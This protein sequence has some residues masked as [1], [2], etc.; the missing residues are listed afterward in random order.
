MVAVKKQSLLVFKK[1][2]LGS[3]QEMNPVMSQGIFDLIT[4]Y[5]VI[6]AF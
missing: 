2:S 3:S 1:K 6:K 4:H 5:E